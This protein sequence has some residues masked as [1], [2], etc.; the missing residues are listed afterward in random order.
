MTD[1][2]TAG[3]LLTLADG[4]A[5]VTLNRPDVGNSIDIPTSHALH[6]IVD[7]LADDASVRVVILRS[8]GRM[9]CAGGDV[10]QMAAA[11]D[12]Q[13][14]LDE[15]AHAIHEA[16]IALRQL[17]VP[18]IAAVHGAAAGAGIGIVLAADIAI[19]SDAASFVAAYSAIGLSPDCGVTALLPSVIGPRRAALMLL[20]NQKFDAA[21]AADWGLVT[22][23][24][25]SDQLEAR[26]AE[27][28]ALVAA[29]PG[30]SARE[31]A[32]LLRRSAERDYASQLE[33]EAV[34]I[35]RLSATPDATRLIEAFA[36]PKS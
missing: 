21:T 29:R 35:A 17:P 16:L 34:T 24:C 1:L 11:S 33:D 26:V 15:L 36:A 22:E 3:V 32:R 6:A 18:V 14:F 25:P 30:E 8:E 31:A 10:R 5:T 20:T 7:Q 23:V 4:I 13:S 19:S 9:F 28:A 27:V 2:D 12:R